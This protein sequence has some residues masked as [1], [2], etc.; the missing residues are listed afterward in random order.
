MDGVI[1][2]AGVAAKELEEETGIVIRDSD[3]VDLSELAYAG[4]PLSKPMTTTTTMTATTSTTAAVTTTTTTTTGAQATVRGV[5][6]TAG[7]S[8]EFIRLFLFRTAITR[9]QLDALLAK[10]HG[11]GGHERIVLRVVPFGDLWRSCADMKTLSAL[12]LY[13]RLRAEGRIPERR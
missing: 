12:C 6:P 10:E 8:D 3:L 5:Y 9:E 1:E 4:M 2:C 13:D 7:G 11:E